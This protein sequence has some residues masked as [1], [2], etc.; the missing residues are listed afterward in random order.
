MSADEKIRVSGET[1]R[2]TTPVLPTVNPGL[3]KS[4]P[5]GAS[6]HP[7]FYVMSVTFILE[8]TFAMRLL[9]TVFAVPGLVSLRPS[10]CSTNG[11][12]IPSTSVRSLLDLVNQFAAPLLT[13]SAFRLPGHS[14]DLPLDFLDRCHPGYGPMDSLP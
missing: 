7:T 5:A 8:L 6:I 12:S 2:A 14:N 1:P 13:F 9:L 4:K 10:F 3:E 11:F